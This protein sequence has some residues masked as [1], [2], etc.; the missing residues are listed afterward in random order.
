M[1]KITKRQS[2]ILESIRKKGKI[3]N[4]EIRLYLEDKIGNLDRATIVRDIDFL[5][6]LKLIAKEGAGRS[7]VYRENITNPLLAFFDPNEYF[8]QEPDKRNIPYE[9]F[10]FDIFP[11]F[12]KNIFQKDELG[13]VDKKNKK[14]LKRMQNLSEANF[15]KEYER[16]SIELSWK[17]SQIEGNTY[18]LLDTEFLIKENREASG[19]TK[20]E[21]LMILNHKKALDYVMKNKKDFRKLSLAKIE[22]I[23]KLLIGGLGVKMNIRKRMVAITGT[24]F[25]PLDNEFQIKEAVGKTIAIM[26]D[27]KIHPIVKALS[28]VL[29][30]SYSQPFED[31]NKRTARIIGNAILLANGYCQLSYRSID[32]KDYKK[33]TLLF[34]E[35]NS[36]LF[37]KELFIQ[38]FEFSVDNY[39]L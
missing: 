35:Q 36:A 5:L 17:S 27:E 29:L 20:E 22:N 39:F 23:H 34:Y 12:S 7:T 4:R 14:Y 2:L 30:I 37:F 24:K 18:T 32:E 1:E 3:S 21:A 26:N 33:A 38:Q 15:K 31:G 11:L 9:K 13:E 28:A 16:L 10:N 19:H 8:K 25:K 6:K